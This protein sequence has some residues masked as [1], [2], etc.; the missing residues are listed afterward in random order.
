MWIILQPAVVAGSSVWRWPDLEMK[1]V[2]S[3][4]PFVLLVETGGIEPPTY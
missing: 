1:R 3:L 4:Q 2:A